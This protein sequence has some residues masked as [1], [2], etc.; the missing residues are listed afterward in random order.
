MGKSRFVW[1]EDTLT[2][3]L[4]SFPAWYQAAVGVVVDRQAGK[5][6]TYMRQNAPWT[7][8]TS[9]AR[10]GLR[11]FA[12]HTKRTH[13]LTLSHGVPYGISLEVRHSGR[14]SIIVPS[15]KVQGD[16]I[17]STLKKLMETL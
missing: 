8:Q 2:G 13:S 16:Q 3:G 14:Y 7:D 9:N 1:V 11:A 15:L 17:M 4:K 10:N 12:G 6:E 5:A